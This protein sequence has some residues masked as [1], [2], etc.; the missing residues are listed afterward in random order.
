[1]KSLVLVGLGGVAL[2]MSFLKAERLAPNEQL[3]LNQL[4]PVVQWKKYV[5]TKEKEGLKPTEPFVFVTEPDIHALIEFERAAQER[6]PGRILSLT[7]IPTHESLGM[8]QLGAQIEH[9]RSCIPHPLPAEWHNPLVWKAKIQNDPVCAPY[10][11]EDIGFLTMYFPPHGKNKS[12]AGDEVRLFIQRN[13][14]SVLKDI[15]TRDIKSHWPQ[16][17]PTGWAWSNYV[18]DFLL[19]EFYALL[20]TVGTM[21]LFA[22]FCLHFHSVRTALVGIF[23]GWVT[24]FI[25]RGT[26]GLLGLHETV[27][28]PL[29]YSILLIVGPSALLRVHEKKNWQW[30]IWFTALSAVGGFLTL[31]PI[32]GGFQVRHIMDM[33]YTASIGIVVMTTLAIYIFPLYSIEKPRGGSSW[34]ARGYETFIERMALLC[35]GAS[36]RLTH[37]CT[38]WGICILVFASFFMTPLLISQ[39]II[40][41]KTD[42]RNY[43]SNTESAEYLREFN[44]NPDGP[45]QT[46]INV[47]FE[48]EQGGKLRDVE[49]PV[50]IRQGLRWIDQIKKAIP[51]VRRVYNPLEGVNQ[52][53][54]VIWERE[55]VTVTEAGM[56]WDRARTPLASL[57]ECIGYTKGVVMGI[58]FAGNDDR[59]MWSIIQQIL[60]VKPANVRVTPFNDNVEY[61]ATG[62]EITDGKIR[63]M[64]SSALYIMVTMIVFLLCIR[65]SIP[66]SLLNPW[67]GGVMG[68]IPYLF[69]LTAF[70]FIVCIMG[71]PLDLATALITAFAIGASGDFAPYFLY[72]LAEKSSRMSKKR[73]FEETAHEQLPAI[74]KDA[75]QNA[76]AFLPLTLAALLGISPVAELG[77]A[78]IVIMVLSYIGT[79]IFM[80]GS[81]WMVRLPGVTRTLEKPMALESAT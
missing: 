41:T 60:A 50:F 66:Q 13:Q 17:R 53:S 16:T 7:T 14:S 15:L 81:L 22:I 56:S 77:Q 34:I 57:W 19:K 28:T 18:L 33:A 54:H 24:L 47:L 21:L 48:V 64:F 43:V 75:V 65:R 27:L 59:E 69:G 12:T 29:A 11:T 10:F 38:P 2:G 68:T 46:Y 73:A 76:L 79:A 37:A 74:L 52:A 70:L 78:M 67:I 62:E 26:M 1:M 9:T 25:Q 80:V 36:S 20:G 3:L 71:K 8:D 61:A 6:W 49:D 31:L 30:V 40:S 4:H 51:Q 44:E 5:E 63:N 58:S 72:T 45:G 32:P 23:L 39:G 35:W 55:A 42:A